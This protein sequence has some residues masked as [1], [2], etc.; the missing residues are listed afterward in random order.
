MLALVATSCS[1]DDGA[2]SRTTVEQSE[3]GQNTADS[4]SDGGGPVNESDHVTLARYADYQSDVYGDPAAWL[5]RPDTDDICDADQDAT[6]IEADG[7]TSIEKW[8]SDPDAKIDCFYVYP[9]I[10]MDQS[11]FSDMDASDDEEGAAALNQVARL[12]SECRVF[13][14]IYRQR[15]LAG[16]ASV[17][18]GGAASSSN[19]DS[20]RTATT[21][22]AAPGSLDFDD[23]FSD[24]LDAW[25]SYMATDNL[26]RGVVLIGHS[27][28]AGLLNRL[29]KTEFD[30]DDHDDVRAL[31]VSAY[32]AGGSVMVPA[33]ATRATVDAD[34]RQVG[35][36]ANI[37]LC[38]TTSQT[39]CVITWATYRADSPPAPGAL[40]GRPDPDDSNLR[41]ACVNP[42]SLTPAD[43]QKEPVTAHSYFPARA[44]AS[45][46]TGSGGGSD[47]LADGAPANTWVEGDVD[48]IT[49]PFVTTPGLLSV[50]CTE[51]D[52]YT[53]LELTTNPDPGP[54]VDDIG[55]DLTPQW[56]MHL[57]DISIVMGDII[58]MVKEQS[59]TYLEN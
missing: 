15:T 40:F 42:A 5:C 24:V 59:A 4:G 52:G 27:Q 33:G 56:G 36:L 13:A 45:I 51:H 46:I 26:G 11:Y 49:T 58:S 10:S 20:G 39:G 14:P 41:S 57:Q 38:T 37:D 30:P 21:T 9:T 8:K 54:R 17:L 50:R 48:P 23:P 43:V 53:Y 1:S 6:V 55:G 22:T 28:G 44:G 3:A 34:G 31:L 29:L 19:T 7:T 47:A 35:D 32:L 12:G 16:L 25:K 18:G 2:S